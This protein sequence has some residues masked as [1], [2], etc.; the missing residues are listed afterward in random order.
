MSLIVH[1]CGG[2]TL[3]PSCDRLPSIVV[4]R[5]GTLRHAHQQNGGRRPRVRRD[6]RVR[7]RGYGAHDRHEPHRPPGAACDSTRCRWSDRTTPTTVSSARTSRRSS[8]SRTRA[9]STS[10][11]RTPRSR[12]Q[13]EDQNVRSL[14]LDL[15]P[16][17]QGGL[18]TY[19]LIRKLT[20]QGPL[21]DPAMAQPGIKVMHIPDFDYNTNCD[22]FVLC[23][24]QV[25]TWSDAAPEPRADRDQPR[26]Q[27]V[28][29]ER[30]RRRWREGAAVGRGEPGQ[31]RHRDPLGVHRERDCSRRTTSASRA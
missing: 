27:A 12:Q 24:R 19:P 13:L 9:R 20:G 25:K 23:L 10:G 18:Y 16:D 30:G 17:P 26:A 4:H 21:T 28:R 2:T 5:R 1:R 7:T 6:R 29:P 11:T 22:T 3:P 31:R 8:S 15:F 14:E